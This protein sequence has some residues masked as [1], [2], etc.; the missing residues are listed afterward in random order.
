VLALSRARA[1]RAAGLVVL[2]AL[3]ALLASTKLSR[4]WILNPSPSM[5]EGVYEL[6]AVDRPI[7]RGD[8]VVVCAPPSVTAFAATYHYLGP[9]PC[10]ANTESL[11]KLVAA[12]EGD[13]VDLGPRSIVVNGR[14]LAT[15]ITLD[16]DRLHHALPRFARGRY[17]L[18]PHQLWLWAPAARSFD[19]RYFGAVDVRDVTNF[20]VPVLVKPAPAELRFSAACDAAGR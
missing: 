15:G 6:R 13:V 4:P 7:A 16:R 14:C 9:G 8:T 2:L 20:A 1:Y 11:L 5:P 18:G 12:V 3:V 10:S 19:S 17:R